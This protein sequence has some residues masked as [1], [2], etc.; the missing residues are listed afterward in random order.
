MTDTLLIFIKNPEKGKAK[1]RLAKTMG[2]DKALEIYLRLLN[3][4]RKQ[5]LELNV[6]R[7][8]YY[9]AFVDHQDE[10]SNEA[11]EKRLQASGDLGNRMNRAF[12][13]HLK[14][15]NKVLIIGSDCAQLRSHHIQDAMD[16]LDQHDVV[17][18]PAKDG[19]Y[20]LL[21]MKSEQAFLFENMPWSEPNLLAE[22][23]KK[24]EEQRIHVF[25]LPELSD[26]DTESE[27]LE[28]GIPFI[29][30]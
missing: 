4:T 1:T 12:S 28:F 8:L 27:W 11:F 14:N 17:I 16:A 13:E 24:S 29:L 30:D 26:V 18:G 19:G 15:G 3:H 2:E 10:W 9:S 5:S 21:G 6:H 7:A 22:T 20:Y 23:L 25:L